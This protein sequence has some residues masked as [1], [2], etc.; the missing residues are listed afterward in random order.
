M[1]HK[2]YIIKNGVRYGPYYYKSYREGGKVKK[3]YFPKS[4]I[5]RNLNHRH[6]IK[7]LLAS[8]FI[9]IIILIG[10]IL[11]TN[12]EIKSRIIL[13]IQTF[14]SGGEKIQGNVN[15]TLKEGELIPRA[16]K[17]NAKLGAQSREH[18]VSD[19]VNA[20]QAYGNFYAEN[21]NLSGS[22]EGYGMIGRKFAYP[23]VSFELLIIG[24]ESNLSY[25]VSGNASK[26]SDFIYMLCENESAQIAA[27]SVKINE[28][29]IGDDKI[30]LGISG[31]EARIS[32]NYSIFEEGFGQ[33][34]IGEGRLNLLI[35][36]SMF[37]L[38]A[39]NGTLFVNVYYNETNISSA[40]RNI[41]VEINASG[42]PTKN[43]T[44]NLNENVNYNVSLL[45]EIP[46]LRIAENGSYLLNLSEYFRGAA[47]YVFTG[48]NASAIFSSAMMTLMPA[49]NFIGITSGRI[50]ARNKSASKESNIFS[51]LVSENPIKIET[52]REQIKVGMPVKWTK[53]ITFE[54]P[55][56][57]VSVKLP[58]EAED[59]V[60]KKIEGDSVEP[61]SA[62]ITPLT[63]SVISTSVVT[64]INLNR[65]PKFIRWIK[66][67]FKK[68]TGRAVN[69]MFSASGLEVLIESNA[70]NYTIEYNTDAPQ[71]T[72]EAMPYGKRVVISAPDNLNYT[73]ILSFTDIQEILS[74]GQENLISIIW[75]EPNISIN[76]SAYDM[77]ENGKI[78]YIE[79][80]TPYLSNQTFEI[81]YIMG[82]ENALLSS[83]TDRG[84]NLA[85]QNALIWN[86]LNKYSDNIKVIII[87]AIVIGIIAGFDLRKKL[88][89][90]GK[91]NSEQRE[92]GKEKSE[93]PAAE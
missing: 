84:E 61:I 15:I 47:H 76:F 42:N 70:T 72:E 89:R 65:E 36:I 35:D 23:N 24:N 75:V 87:A 37:N 80:I 16:A 26:G 50:T 51:I 27:G 83:E 85:S 17:I 55:I 14:Y 68:L 58:A 62:K 93:M 56:A 31:N 32:T 86:A 91:D 7:P 48:Q 18:A 5:N 44:A 1:V 69:E 54:A 40:S 3:L 49:E 20:S 29:A 53:T 90:K 92:K 41:L 79:W 43:N 88:R 78:D 22:G 34:F 4:E 46:T 21:A 9:I 11:I 81:R 8:L 38:T 52:T 10:L 13:D 19:V 60:V 82:G 12:L 67:L 39:E 45:K 59:I 64:E 63:A 71:I 33:E 25:S 66:S 30:N 2:K 6:K 77:N 57:N 28:T 73:N 74:V